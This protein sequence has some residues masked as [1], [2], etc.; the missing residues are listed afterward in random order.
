MQLK[1]AVLFERMIVNLA[2]LWGRSWRSDKINPEEIMNEIHPA[3]VLFN[4]PF[5]ETSECLFWS[6]YKGSAADY[7]NFMINAVAVHGTEALL[8]LAKAFEEQWN[9]QNTKH[10]WQ[11]GWKRQIS[12]VSTGQGV[13]QR[14]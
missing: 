1:C 5:V 9:E 12:L 10:Y 14:Y 13:P 6:Q 7:F 2:N 11:T 8:A 4:K 3:L